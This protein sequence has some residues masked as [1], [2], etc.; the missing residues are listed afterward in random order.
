MRYGKPLPPPQIERRA[1]RLAR[2]N[3]AMSSRAF[4]KP[5]AIARSLYC[6]SASPLVLIQKAAQLI[7]LFFGR[8]PALQRL[9]HQFACRPLENPLQDVAHELPFS[10][11]RRLACLITVRPLLFVSAH[12]ALRSHALNQ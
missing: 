5:P 12:P 10:P 6:S 4:A 2:G 1:L 8:S 7:Q 3:A 9:A 11:R